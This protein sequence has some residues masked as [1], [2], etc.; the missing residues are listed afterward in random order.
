MTTDIADADALEALSQNP[1][2]IEDQETLAAV[3]THLDQRIAAIEMQIERAAAQE[4][5][6][7]VTDLEWLHRASTALGYLKATRKSLD[8][9]D[10]QLRAYRR[11]DAKAE[12]DAA[13]PERRASKVEKHIRFMAQVE[14]RRQVR[15]LEHERITLTRDRLVFE[16]SKAKAFMAAARRVLTSEQYAEIMA[17]VEKYNGHDRPDGRVHV[18]SGRGEAVTD[19]GA[20]N[21][22]VV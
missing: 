9:R 15:A 19:D 14:E 11:Q 6:V 1:S 20:A 18:A 12:I 4:R 8:R 22:A 21:G 13:A 7:G 5:V 2:A 10:R 16:R 3:V 17:E